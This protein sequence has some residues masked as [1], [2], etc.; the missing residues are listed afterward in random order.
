[1]FLSDIVGDLNQE[2]QDTLILSNAF[3]YWTIYYR[4][5]VDSFQSKLWTLLGPP[6]KLNTVYVSINE[7]KL[8]NG[9]ATFTAAV[10]IAK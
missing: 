7:M 8:V 9:N 3:F 10:S 5:W 4:L 2:L 1:M 6:K